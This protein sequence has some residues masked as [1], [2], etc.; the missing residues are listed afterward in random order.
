[1]ARAARSK[2]VWSRARRWSPRRTTSPPCAAPRPR[3]WIALAGLDVI[4]CDDGRFR[5]IEDQ[6]RMPSGLA[7]AVA[8][9]DTLRDLLAVEPPQPDVS[10][11][12]GELALALQEA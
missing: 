9:R 10:L 2:R 7:Y 3:R 5:V 8:W 6:L 4:R 11:V 1:M 12:F